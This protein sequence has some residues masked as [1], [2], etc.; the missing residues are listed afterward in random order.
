MDNKMK[1]VL[2]GVGGLVLWFTPFAYVDF[3]GM[4]AYQA[5]QHIGGIAYLLL[6]ASIAYAALSWVEQYQLAVVAAGVATGICVLFALQAGT[7]IAWGLILLLILSIV[8]IVFAVRSKKA[9]ST[10]QETAKE[11]A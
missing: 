10:Q 3:M 11:G 6:V 5:G 2:L 1:G 4:N 9:K 7:A 8:S